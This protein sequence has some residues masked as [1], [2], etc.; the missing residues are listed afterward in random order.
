MPVDTRMPRTTPR[1]WIRAAERSAPEEQWTLLCYLAGQG[2]ETEDGE[3]HAA[4]R[5]AELLLAAGGDPHRPLELYGRAVT[6]LAADLDDPR[7]REQLEAG[8]DRLT[9][10]T[11]GLRGASEALRLLRSDRDLAWQCYALALLADALTGDD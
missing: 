2:V 9:A 8:L 3:L 6:A 10:E 1:D 5:R 11:A 7:A 4:I